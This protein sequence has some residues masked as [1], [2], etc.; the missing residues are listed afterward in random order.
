MSG[1]VKTYVISP[2]S[3]LSLTSVSYDSA[4]FSGVVAN[5]QELLN[6]QCS[7]QFRFGIFCGTNSDP[8]SN[9]NYQAEL[10]DDGSFTVTV[11][12]LSPNTKY[13]YGLVQTQSLSVLYGE[14]FEFTTDEGSPIFFKTPVMENEGCI[15]FSGFPTTRDFAV[16]AYAQDGEDAYSP[17]AGTVDVYMDEVKC[18]CVTDG[19]A[20]VKDLWR[21]MA[22]NYY[23]PVDKSLTF[24]AVSPSQD[25][26]STECNYSISSTKSA[27][28]VEYTAPADPA[29]QVDILYSDWKKN[30][31]LAA[32][33]NNEVY[34]GVELAFR[35][36]LSSVCFK[37]SVQS[38]CA[39]VLQIKE[40][41]VDNIYKGG[42]FTND[43]E[44]GIKSWDFTG[45]TKDKYVY[46]CLADNVINVENF[47]VPQAIGDESCITVHFSIKIVLCQ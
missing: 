28:I 26:P 35:H 30:C 38:E 42:V 46:E 11:S 4:V 19:V 23:W 40:I 3:S 45:Q 10:H 9:N 16:F 47:F 22:Q 12:G 44:T 15:Y 18:E 41:S 43:F 34:E 27:L 32:N 8:K 31:T 24:V 1:E 7:S 13:Y 39:E 14:T 5:Y 2:S 33:E 36:A 29:K 17:G 20:G 6:F 37:V 21:P 25:V